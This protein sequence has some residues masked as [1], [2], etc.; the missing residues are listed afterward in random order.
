MKLWDIDAEIASVTE[1]VNEETGELLP[2]ALERLEQLMRERE[3]TLEWIALTVKNLSSDAAAIKAEI[4]NLTARK[5][6]AQRRADKLKDFL[7]YALQGVKLNTPRVAVSYRKSTA[8]E[9]DENLFWS[10]A[11]DHPEYARRKDP[12]PEK[13]AITD[14]IKS[15]LDIPG[16]KL[17]ER[18]NMTIK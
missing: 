7:Q 5:Q 14:A 10:F 15:G 8:L 9:I 1:Q 13:K 4:D 6:A 12:E 11:V 17:V 3:D 16:A 2:E 18:T